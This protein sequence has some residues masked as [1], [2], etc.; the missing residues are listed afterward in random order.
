[1]VGPLE[2]ADNWADGKIEVNINRCF[3]C[4][5][6]FK[7]CWHTEEEH[8]SAFNEIGDAILGLFPNANITGNYEIPELLDEFEVYVRGLGFKS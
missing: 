3:D 2:L 5:I 4:F 7:Y 6:H 1:M 8:I